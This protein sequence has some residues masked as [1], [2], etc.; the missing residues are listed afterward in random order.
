MRKP[1]ASI[2]RQFWPR[3]ETITGAS[4][5]PALSPKCYF[6]LQRIRAARHEVFLTM[7]DF[8][9][10]SG[11]D[12]EAAVRTIEKISR[13]ERR[14]VSKRKRALRKPAT[15]WVNHIGAKYSQ[16]LG[17][18]PKVRFGRTKPRRLNPFFC[19]TNPNFY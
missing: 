19:R 1:E 3:A 6:E 9:N 13:Y 5:K 14:A 16:A 2:W 7:G 4:S 18:K 15:D 11:S 8:E 10:L 17:L 12:P